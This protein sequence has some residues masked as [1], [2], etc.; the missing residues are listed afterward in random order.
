MGKQSSIDT[1]PSQQSPKE[2]KC[3]C[4]RSFLCFRERVK[5]FTERVKVWERASFSLFVLGSFKRRTHEAQQKLPGGRKVPGHVQCVARGWR[6]NGGGCVSCFSKVS[7][8][9][10]A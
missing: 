4:A 7:L 2:V 3:V 9:P 1:V 5:A 10:A 6:Q 8:L